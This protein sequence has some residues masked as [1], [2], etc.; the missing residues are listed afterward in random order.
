MDKMICPHA[1]ACRAR[2]ERDGIGDMLGPR[3]R[4]T[5]ADRARRCAGMLGLKAMWRASEL[6][7]F[8]E[9]MR[10]MRDG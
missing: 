7:A 9:G 4:E 1:A 3:C 2:A 10:R 5:D 8:V 6:I